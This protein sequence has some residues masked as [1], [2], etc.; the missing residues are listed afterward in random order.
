[1]LEI[2]DKVCTVGQPKVSFGILDRGLR[3][4]VVELDNDFE[5][6]RGYGV[7]VLFDNSILSEPIWFM[8]FELKRLE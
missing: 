1:M 5:H 4:Q 3:G 6:V 7:R 2:G 8:D